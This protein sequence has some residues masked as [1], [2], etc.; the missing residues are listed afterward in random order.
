[1]I[2]QGPNATRQA[3][4]DRTNDNLIEAAEHRGIAEDQR[5]HLRATQ[6]AHIHTE[7]VCPNRIKI[8]ETVGGDR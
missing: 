7:N 6:R 4:G 8:E 2:H 3:R 5:R 1:M